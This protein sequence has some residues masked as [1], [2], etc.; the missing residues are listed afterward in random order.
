MK[1]KP[2]NLVGEVLTKP[3]LERFHFLWTKR[4]NNSQLFNNWI[5]I[6][7]VTQKWSSLAGTVMNE[8]CIFTVTISA[9][10]GNYA[11]GV[12]DTVHHVLP[13]YSFQTGLPGSYFMF[14]CLCGCYTRKK[15]GD[16]VL[17]AKGIVVYILI[18]N[19]TLAISN[20]LFACQAD[21]SSPGFRTESVIRLCRWICEFES[22]CDPLSVAAVVSPL[23]W[24]NRRNFRDKWVKATK[25][26]QLIVSV[27]YCWN[28]FSVKFCWSLIYWSADKIN[29]VNI[30][31]DKHWCYSFKRLTCDSLIFH[32]LGSTTTVVKG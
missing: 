10:M 27:R 19:T 8:W 26:K 11:I 28:I 7:L 13:P 12:L 2:R 31:M 3:Y 6:R 5:N 15:G 18:M 30:L 24:A 32:R 1:G 29:S 17:D 22:V 4:I 23:C 21:S 14:H 16:A 20:H 25:K 9:A